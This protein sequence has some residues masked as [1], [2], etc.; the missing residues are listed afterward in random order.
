MEP[1]P[2]PDNNAV[3]E[4]FTVIHPIHGKENLLIPFMHALS[5]AYA[6]KGELEV[7]DARGKGNRDKDLSIRNVFERWG[8]L[9]VNSKREDVE[10]SL[11]IRIKK[12]IKDGGPKKEIAKRLK[13]REHDILVAGLHEQKGLGRLFGQDLIE[14]LVQYF[15][16]TTLY[17]PPGVKPFV[18]RDNGEMILNKI[19]IPVADAPSPDFSFQ[20]L[21]RLLQLIPGQS[22]DVYGVHV[23]NTFPLVPAVFIEDIS[24]N[25]VLKEDSVP[26]SIIALAKEEDADLIIMSTNGRDTITQKIAGSITEQVLKDTPCPV[27]AVAVPE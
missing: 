14:Y 9:P 4:R 21:H 20:M 25:E 22:P 1:A 10:K 2:H 12:I 17:M 23:G 3:E 27:L 24:W 13:R 16:Q 5:L 11:N 6:L 8:K 7:I 15:R 18:N 26:Q 19:I